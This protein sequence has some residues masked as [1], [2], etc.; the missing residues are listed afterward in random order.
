MSGVDKDALIAEADQLAA[1]LKL[2][3]DAK[4]AA[5]QADGRPFDRAAFVQGRDLDVRYESGP[6]FEPYRTQ[7]TLLSLTLGITWREWAWTLA[8]AAVVYGTAFYHGEDQ[9]AACTQLLCFH[10]TVEGR[11][12]LRMRLPIQEAA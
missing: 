7:P 4:R 10:L 5:L 11:G 2:A 8:G 1:K 3:A 9:F 12:L 6:G